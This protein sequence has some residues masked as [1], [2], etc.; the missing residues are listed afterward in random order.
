MTIE[1]SQDFYKKEVEPALGILNG[2]VSTFELTKATME[3]VKDRAIETGEI[4]QGVFSE[5][6]LFDEISERQARQKSKTAKELLGILTESGTY[7]TKPGDGAALLRAE[8]ELAAASIVEGA[9][10]LKV[11]PNEPDRHKAIYS[12][13]IDRGQ[14]VLYG[15]LDKELAASCVAVVRTGI[16]PTNVRAVE[17]A[18]QYLEQYPWVEDLEGELPRIKEEKLKAFSEFLHEKYAPTFYLLR[19]EFG[20]ISNDNLVQVANRYLELRGFTDKGWT[21]EPNPRRTGFF[22][23][24]GKNVL[25]SGN[26]SVQ[27][28]WARFEELMMHEVEIHMASTQNPRDIEAGALGSSSLPGIADVQEGTGMVAEILWK[29]VQKTEVPGRDVFR[30][31]AVAYADGIYNGK[32]HTEQET[33]DFI[34]STMT[35]QGL[36]TGKDTDVSREMQKARQSSFDH[37]YRIY[38]G[39]PP[40]HILRRNAGYLMGKTKIIDVINET[41]KSPAE[42]F[43]CFQQSK[44]DPTNPQHDALLREYNL[45][46]L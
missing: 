26:R 3:Q 1:S 41:D 12:N 28:T 27:I 35:L 14:E 36:K 46:T 30:Y 15:Q 9:R 37:V 29:G 24:A 23:N 31:M 45:P 17:F 40:G 7:P 6:P 42:V 44:T 19:S 8:G 38:R 21:C 43:A 18:N 33:Y 22:V 16:E 32:K 10:M 25:E 39:M 5:I 13:E 34:T 11:A 20:E 2:P 4:D